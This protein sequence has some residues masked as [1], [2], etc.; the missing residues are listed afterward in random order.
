MYGVIELV[1]V[2]L[3]GHMCMCMGVNVPRHVCARACVCWAF[4]CMG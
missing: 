2:R 1:P 3:Q 4:M